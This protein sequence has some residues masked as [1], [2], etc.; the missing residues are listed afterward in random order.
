MFYSDPHILQKLLQAKKHSNLGRYSFC[1]K[2]LH[3]AQSRG[4]VLE[5]GGGLATHFKIPHHRNRYLQLA[6][7]ILGRFTFY[8]MIWGY[9]DQQKVTLKIILSP[10]NFWLLKDVDWNF[11]CWKSQSSSLNG[12][13]TVDSESWRS[14]KSKTFWVRGYVFRKFI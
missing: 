5:G 3:T 1:N 4:R 11:N 14:K 12:Y 2:C 10:Y 6:Q 7:L 9:F 8:A 13:K